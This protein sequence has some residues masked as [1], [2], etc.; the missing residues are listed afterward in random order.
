MT[1]DSYTLGFVLAS[2]YRK[3]VMI[4]L[5]DKPSTPSVISE[6]TKI[7]PS[8]ISNTLS[9]LVEKKLVVCL[10]PKLK[11]GRLYELTVNGKKFLKNI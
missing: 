8:H 1:D 7:Y 4:A 3:K 11:K 6:K 10:T 9:E 5:Q 2:E